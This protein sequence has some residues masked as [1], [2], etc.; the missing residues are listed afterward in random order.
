MQALSTDWM[1][2]L[3]LAVGAAL[4]AFAI[5]GLRN[6]L[7]SRRNLELSVALEQLRGLKWRKFAHFVVALLEKR[8]LSIDEQDRQP[9]EGGVD[10]MMRRGNARYIVQCKHSSAYQLNDAGI[11]E[12]VKLIHMQSA[13]GAILVNAGN[14]DSRLHP[15]A[16]RH[17]VEILEG[18]EL[19]EQLESCLPFDIV[20]H[21]HQ[22]TARRLQRKRRSAL[23]AAGLFALIAAAVGFLLGG[24]AQE[25]APS[26]ISAP[27]DP[28]PRQT[29]EQTPA[30]VPKEAT[31]ASE[32]TATG[33]PAAMPDPD[34][35]EAEI[36]RRREQAEKNVLALTGIQNASWSTRSTM[37]LVLPLPDDSAATS[38]DSGEGDD[39][40]TDEDPLAELVRSVCD[41]LTRFEELRYTRLQI[42]YADPNDEN[43]ARVRWRQ[44]R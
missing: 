22:E 1:I 20:E 9:G 12:L 6:G 15:L 14:A 17:G 18:R 13:A 19:W 32:T 38:A 25:P 41:E 34:M 10:L 11:Q 7:F 39:K 4:L 37:V 36:A 26:V 35:S 27:P 29:T 28:P 2:P 33:I 40:P 24:P 3:A 42:S 43:E 5:V 21:I 44:C 31:S 8:G 30:A 23:A 16:N